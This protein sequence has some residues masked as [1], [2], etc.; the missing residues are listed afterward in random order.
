MH[1]LDKVYN[2]RIILKELLSDE[3]D[4]S[5]INDV[6]LKELEIMY[7]TQMDNSYINSGCNFTLTN[8]TF[9]SHKLHIIYYNFP[10]LHLKGTKINKSC[11]DKLLS[12]YKKEG[13]EDEGS[14]FN[15]ED[16]LL[17]II[18]EPISSSIEKS[19]ENMY[20]KGQNVLLNTGLSEQ[21]QKEIESN[22]IIIDKSY[23]RNIHIFHIDTLVN[24]LLKH[25]YVPKH[26]VIRDKNEINKIY[27]LTNTNSYQL[28]II[29]R[30]DAIAKLIRLCP[31]DICKITRKSI[32]A[33]NSV[34]YRIC[35]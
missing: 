28:P 29:L 16:S 35:K 30:T 5:I 8:T 18:N 9:P 6:S 24:N 7:N 31:G 10:E 12:L 34:Y 21:I 3:W 11:C 20:L 27:T 4:T 1:L 26:E 22:K 33:G 14:I 19:V 13:F 15:P 2:T 23:F 32:T 17:V 25:K